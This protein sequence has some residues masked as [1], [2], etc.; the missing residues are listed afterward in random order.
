MI[1]LP[2]A[3]AAFDVAYFA[4]PLRTNLGAG[5]AGGALSIFDQE[6]TGDALRALDTQIVA[7]A[8]A[9]GLTVTEP[10]RGFYPMGDSIT[11][12]SI[13]DDTF[14]SYAD[15]VL[16]NT[17]GLVGHN[18]SW[19]GQA[20]AQ[21]EAVADRFIP[22]WQSAVAAGREVIVSLMI[23]RND[24]STLISDWSA[25]YNE[26]K[27]VGTKI[28]ATGAKLIMCDILPSDLAG[29]N[30]ARANFNAQ[31]AADEGSWFDVHADFS[32]VVA[33]QDG[34]E[35]NATYYSDGTHPTQAGHNNLYPVMQSAYDAAVA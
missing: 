3:M 34:T 22:H 17:A 4:L 5:F 16:L 23:G 6:L 33:G 21:Q 20:L 29:F 25:Y 32:G 26:V 10:S 18:A 14:Y 19:P 13:S 24:S 30:A 11:N 1:V 7:E 15:G 9:A 2:E 12:G 35:S 8:T 28:K 31:L 27:A